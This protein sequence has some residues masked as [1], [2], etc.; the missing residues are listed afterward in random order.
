MYKLNDIDLLT[1]DII[2]GRI[3]GGNISVSGI[4]DFPKRMGDTHHSWDDEN[5]TEPYVDT[6]EL[7]FEGRDIIFK[8]V[9]LS[10]R[11][12]A[13]LSLE[14]LYAAI[15]AFTSQVV[16]STPFGDFN[17]TVLSITPIHY[18][19]V[20]E[21]EIKMREP[22]VDLTGTLPATGSGSYKV[23]GIP[24]TS[25]GLY[26]AGQ[27]D[28]TGLPESKV[29]YFNSFGSEGFQITKRQTNKLT[30][31]GMLTGNDISDFTTKVKA[32]Y[33]LFSSAG[34]R[35]FNLAG[36]VEADAFAV[37]GFKVTDIIV[38]SV[39]VGEFKIELNITEIVTI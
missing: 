25:F 26:I 15:H 30:L 12:N 18:P 31:T 9:I 34:L 37:E 33:K 29:Q 10:G 13:Y 23:D 22:V 6:D 21:V 7:F 28:I 2:P 3:P 35:T 20:T 4:Y 39:V 19:D 36:E 1:Y 8:G 17:V 38:S 14:I 5:G 27:K 16:F 11:Q 32:L 24:L